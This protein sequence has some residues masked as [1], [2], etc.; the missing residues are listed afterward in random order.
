MSKQ[1]ELNITIDENGTI[2]VTP[3][4]THGDECLN[5]M[6]FFDKVEGFVTVETVKN[7]DYKTKKVQLNTIQKIQ[8]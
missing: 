1:V 7:E 2:H 5:L 8:K 6:S 3:D 4:G